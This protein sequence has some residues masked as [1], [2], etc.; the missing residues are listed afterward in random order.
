MSLLSTVEDFADQSTKLARPVLPHLARMLLV[1]TFLEDGIRM[2]TQWTEQREYI[3]IL[4]GCGHLLAS[5]FVFINLVGQIGAVSMVVNRFQINVACGILLFIVA[6]QTIAFSILTDPM[7]L[8][9]N[10]ALCGAVLLVAAED[11]VEDKSTFAGVPSVG[12]DKRPKSYLQL[13]GRVLLSLMFLVLLR[14]EAN[15]LQILYTLVT[16]L[17]MLLISVGYKTKVSAVLLFVLLLVHNVTH[18]CF[19][20]VGSRKPLHDFLKYDFFQ[21][22]SFMGGLLMVVVIGPGEVSIDG[23]KKQ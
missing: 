18:N 1:A 13:A 10:L 21:T 5:I 22:L 8:L 7:F 17:L 15:P 23:K 14:L 19:W 6:L 9:R 12:E 2:W 4:W 16:S 3:M 11:W 20:T